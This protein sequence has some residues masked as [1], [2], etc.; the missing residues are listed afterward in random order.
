MTALW[1]SPQREHIPL[2][3]S[4]VYFIAVVTGV[5]LVVHVGLYGLSLRGLG[6]GAMTG[7]AAS[8]A[9][10]AAWNHILWRLPLLDAGRPQVW[11]TWRGELNGYFR[12]DEQAGAQHVAIPVYAVVRQSATNATYEQLQDQSRSHTLYS[13]LT[14]HEGHWYLRGAYQNLPSDPALNQHRGSYELI[15]TD[16]EI[17]GVYWNERWSKGTIQFTQRRPVFAATVA[18]A[19]R[20]FGD[21]QD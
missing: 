21:N 3:R 2:Q 17:E 5:S 11:G 4:L 1:V 20:L 9:A 15:L 13:H 19:K 6:Q 12:N 10:H 7:A 16:H 18:Q 8:L 14:K